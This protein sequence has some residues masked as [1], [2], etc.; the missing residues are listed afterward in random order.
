MA[1]WSRRSDVR[2][3]TSVGTRP[4]VTSRSR[5]TYLNRLFR[6]SQEAASVSTESLGSGCCGCNVERIAL[7]E[8]NLVTRRSSTSKRCCSRAA[9][10]SFGQHSVHTTSFHQTSDSFSSSGAAEYSDRCIAF[11]SMEI[12]TLRHSLCSEATCP[13]TAMPLT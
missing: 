10:L 8:T 6:F 1:R 3:Y 2:C 12:R 4:L 13:Q 9:A 5:D 11:W 7:L